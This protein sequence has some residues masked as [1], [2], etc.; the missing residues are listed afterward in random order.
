MCNRGFSVAFI[1][2]YGACDLG[3]YPESPSPCSEIGDVNV[4][5]LGTTTCA[6]AEVNADSGKSH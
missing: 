5:T 4:E 3:I 6:T 2:N 1:P